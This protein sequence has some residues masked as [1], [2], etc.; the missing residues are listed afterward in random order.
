MQK[1]IE[2]L[3]QNLR[4]YDQHY[5]G[6]DAPLVPDTEY[7]R[8]MN[9][10]IELEKLNPS[11]ITSDSPTQ[12][13]GRASSSSLA[14][15]EHLRPMLSLNNV[16]FD[17]DLRQFI[18]RIILQIG[19]HEIFEFSAEPKLDGLAVNLI[20]VDGLLISCATRGDGL[21]GENITANIKTIPSVPLKLLSDTLPKRVEVRG[22]VY[23]SKKSFQT[24]NQYALRHHEKQFANPRNAAAGSLRQ[25]DP[26]ITAKRQLSIFVYG[27]GVCEGIILPNTHTEQMQLLKSWGFRVCPLNEKVRNI[28]G[29]LSY[30]QKILEKRQELPYEIDGVVYKLNSI[31][32]QNEMGYVAKAPRFACAHKFPAMEEVTQ[33]ESVDFQ[34]GRTGIITPVARLSPVNVGGVTVRNASLHNFSE[35][36]RKDIH[37]GDY[38]MIRRAGDVIPEVVQ[39]ILPRRSEHVRPIEYPA[40]CPDCQSAI[41]S[42]PD[43]ILIR[44]TAGLLCPSQLEGALKHFVSRKAMAID[45]IG[46][47]LIKAL[48]ENKWV[49]DVADIYGITTAQWLALPRMAKKSVEN[50]VLGIKK[51]KDTTFA[52]VLYALGI[53]E[54]GEVGAKTLASHYQDFDSLK[55]ANFLDLLALPDFGPVAS[56]EVVDFFGNPRLYSICEKLQ[57][58]GIVWRKKNE[59]QQVYM[60]LINKTVVLTGTLKQYTREEVTELLENHGA[61]ITS[62]ISKKTDFLLLGEHPG[63]KYEKALALGVKIV[64]EDELNQLLI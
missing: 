9:Q 12:R 4:L 10:L 31:L 3:R 18:E 48:V 22:E 5:Y 16:F 42:E 28:E 27:L 7:D 57:A 25:L 14:P 52:R 29:C 40:L 30:Y 8:L 21:V 17:E 1:K 23:M 13:V 55:K 34:V 38:V 45:G 58:A 19:G 53:R 33:L 43:G 64:T 36:K 2:E 62:A 20:Y 46:E 11:L 56:K 24:L 50:I 44:C 54:I 37:I 41:F 35:I 39:V 6:M 15:I 60:G 32:A 26:N 47:H 63:S 59:E 49:A 51:S 61:K